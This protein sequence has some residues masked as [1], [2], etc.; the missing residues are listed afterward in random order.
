MTIPIL[1]LALVMALS[2][3]PAQALQTAPSPAHSPTAAPKRG[4]DCSFGS[5]A[6][7]W[8]LTGRFPAPR[9]ERRDSVPNDILKQPAAR[10]ASEE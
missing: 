3:H 5:A 9:R 7:C 1:L 6:T 8:T 4:P 10:L 2:A